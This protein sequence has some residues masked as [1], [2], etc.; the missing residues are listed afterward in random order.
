MDP[1]QQ[2]AQVVEVKNCVNMLITLGF[3]DTIATSASQWQGDPSPLRRALYAHFERYDLTA[4]RK[5][6][7]KDDL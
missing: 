4:P 7:Q 3:R 2:N 6:P 5:G 1:K